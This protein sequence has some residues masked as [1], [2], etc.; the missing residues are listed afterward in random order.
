MRPGE[1][2]E[3]EITSLSL[4]GEGLGT[5]EDREMR[6]HGAFPGERVRVRVEHVSKQH[7]RADARRLEVLTPTTHKRP[8][9]CPDDVTNGGRC[10]GCA[11]STI[12]VEAQQTAKSAMLVERFGLDA[13]LSSTGPEW[14]YRAS[15]KRIAFRHGPRLG[16]GSYVRDT[17]RA[18]S[19]RHC[20]V[21][22]PRIAAV[23]RQIEDL[24][25]ELAIPPYD[26][27][28]KTGT[29]RAVW[30]RTDG[31]HVLVTLVVVREDPTLFALS[32]RLEGVS[33]VVRAIARAEG[34]DLRG[35]SLTVLRGHDSLRIRMNEETTNVSAL[36]FF[37]PNPDVAAQAYDELV[38]ASEGLENAGL[39]LDLYAGAGI[40]TKM[41]AKRFAEVVPVESFPEAARALGIEPSGVAETLAKR[42]EANA[43]KPVFVVANPPR[44]GLGDAV[45]RSLI[46]LAPERIAIMSCHPGSLS[47]DLALLEAGGYTR[48]SVRWFDTLPNTPHVEVV[49]RLDRS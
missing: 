24:A 7:P 49:V 11:L 37:Q 35:A 18:A 6:V 23:A 22:H 17:H 43:P 3:V 32:A 4:E 48:T 25:T 42:L 33:G 26:E 38:R 39:A 2:L 15:S 44:A 16:L 13:V 28:T 41:L 20:R 34:N 46:A 45:C 8:S 30:L 9:P 47:R 21:E 40:T 14:G 36:S 10:T 29:L 31:E 19:M 1:H 12:D 5:Y 27:R